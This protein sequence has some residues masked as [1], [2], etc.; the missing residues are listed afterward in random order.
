MTIAIY[1]TK[2]DHVNK[3][4]QWNYH[5]GFDARL[6]SSTTFPAAGP[7]LLF[8]QSQ[9][10]NAIL[11]TNNATFFGA[12]Q[13]TQGFR[14]M[15]QLGTTLI[16][17]PFG[18][19]IGGILYPFGVSFLLPI[20][21][22]TLVQ[23]KESRILVMMKMNGV[24]SF[25]YYLSH[26]ITFYTLYALSTLAFLISG[27]IGKLTFFTLTEKPVL[28]LMFFIWGHN[29]ISLAFFFSTLF[30]KS[31]LALVSVFL[32]VLCS[33]VISLATD[34]IFTG[35]APSA[36]FIWPPFAF[37]RALTLVN[38]ASYLTT[39]T[40]YTMKIINSGDEVQTCLSFMAVEIFVFLFL[41]W[42]LDAVFPTEFGLQKPWHFIFSEPRQLY[43]SYRSRKINGVDH[44]S[45]ATMAM[46][47]KVDESETR[48]EDEDVKEERN[49]VLQTNLDEKQY[50]LIMKNMRKV[51]AGRGGAGPKLAVKDVTLAIEK[52]T[53]F[54]L[55]GPN[56]AGKS[57][58][59][60]ILTGL[61]S[62][63]TGEAQIA[64][65]DLTMEGVYR[66]IGICPQVFLS[67]T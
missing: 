34:T 25:A 49:R 8:Q 23:E 30:N 67:L 26:Y 2:I 46:A 62:A 3:R 4:Y 56:G 12:A 45:E 10:D 7:R 6:T 1:F 11:R 36:Y 16:S 50:P 35:A 31:R 44:H 63:S 21:A 37:Y 18:G 58:L 65:L 9:L 39:L 32:I 13:I 55:L 19:I 15:P 66:K 22:I 41:A 53:I 59:I 20:F 28:A 29:Q 27:G 52:N 33:V 64:G 42:Y 43:Q 57:T 24:K 5:Y 47:I 17:I 61:Y 40:P 60:S 48:H 51:Y 38:K 14:I 54:G